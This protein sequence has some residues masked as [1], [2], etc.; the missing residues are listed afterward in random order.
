MTK[1]KA[2]LI[3]VLGYFA[4]CL[5]IGVNLVSG[6]DVELPQFGVSKRSIEEAATS[7]GLS[8]GFTGPEI[9][10]VNGIELIQF[11]KGSR[12]RMSIVQFGVSKKTKLYG[13]K[14][15]NIFVAKNSQNSNQYEKECFALLNV[16]EKQLKDAGYVLVHSEGSMKQYERGDV[17][18]E[19][20]V[21]VN[22]QYSQF[23]TIFW[24]KSAMGE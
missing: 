6:A 4:F 23:T 1:V 22:E 19:M 10:E 11:V 16:F 5:W 3:L 13:L 7:W 15:Y 8:R 2:I 17:V 9:S 18:V 20:G 24:S 21:F 12:E 14:G